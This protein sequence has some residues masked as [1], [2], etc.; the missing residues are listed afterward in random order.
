MR[1]T[2]LAHKEIKKFLKPGDRVIDAT[3][4]NGYDT[5]FLANLVQMGLF[6]RLIFKKNQLR[7]ALD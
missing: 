1:L 6:L 5:Q 4:G 2:E 3:A 7:R